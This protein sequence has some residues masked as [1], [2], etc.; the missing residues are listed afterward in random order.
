MKSEKNI[1]IAFILNIGFSI[2]ELLGGFFTNS[3][4]IMS[5]AIHDF[6]DALSIGI[7]YF[8]EKK[9]KKEADDKYTYGYIK[10]RRTKKTNKRRERVKLKSKHKT[11]I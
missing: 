3:I 7:S 9:S 1:L 11:K 8:L 5:D 6:G 2:F 4:S 10:Q